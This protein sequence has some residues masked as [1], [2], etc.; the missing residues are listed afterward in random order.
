MNINIKSKND[1]TFD[2][3]VVGTGISGGWSAKELTE[4][5]LKT[6]VLERGRNV[7]HIVDYPTMNKHPWEIPYADQITAR[8]RKDYEKQLRT[9]YT[10]KQTTKHWW[11]K[12]TD[13]PYQEA[14]GA[15][16]WIRGYHVGGRS[17]VWGRHVYRWSDLDFEANI[18]EGIAVDWPIRY[19][20]I[21]KWYD[22]VETFI[23][24]S[25]RKEG[26]SQLPDGKF[27]PPFELNCVEKDFRKDLKKKFSN[28]I[29]TPGRIAHITSD[30]K[31]TGRGKCQSRNLCI[32][33]CPF[34]GYFSSNSGT[35]PAA[36]VTGNMT[37]RPH[38]IVH[39]IIYDEEKE[40]AIGVRVRDDETLEEIEFYSKIIFLNASTVNSTSIL[41]NSISKRFPNG[42]GNDSGELG[43][44][45]MDHH[46]L[47]GARAKIDGYEDMYYTRG[48]PCGIYM[49]RFRNL[50][51]ERMDF[52]RG[53]GYQG[54]ASRGS[55]SS[56]GESVLAG[57][58]LVKNAVKPG[59]WT[60][61]L[62]GFGEILP[63]HEN[64]CI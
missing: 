64:K 16:D 32:R 55:W 47:V 5:G 13:Q 29:L 56:A 22:Y 37:L 62:L 19:K 21:E 6:L 27:L 51:K 20:D 52:L 41:L 2:A 15:F 26:L 3:I 43:H 11:V 38:S 4:A 61:N 48:R 58:D 1:N 63:Y 31:F 50:G 42:L 33:G 34:G 45:M 23:G 57:E 14:S 39:S 59:Q 44:N 12:D 35:L 17:L 60:M 7:K 28:R 10:V 9:G 53:Y 40:K 46:F 54:G 8:E 25:G 30:R 49:P 18:R 24:I 36:E